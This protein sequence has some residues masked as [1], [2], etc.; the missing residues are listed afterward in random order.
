LGVGI[1]A[2]HALGTLERWHDPDASARSWRRSV[3]DLV[4][5]TWCAPLGRAIGPHR[6][7]V[8]EGC[9]VDVLSTAT[10]AED[11]GLLVIG[12]RGTRSDA[13]D[14]S[15][16]TSL[17]LLHLA[18][19]PVLLVPAGR[20]RSDRSDSLRLRRLLVGVD[21]SQT[22][23]AALVLA[24]EVADRLGGSLNVL[25]V[26]NRVGGFA[27][28]GS[29]RALGRTMTLVEAEL[30]AIRDRGVEAHTVVRSGDAAS[31]LVEIADDVDADLVVVG[32]RGRGGQGELLPGGVSRT[33]ADRVGRPTL[34]VPAAAG[35]VHLPGRGPQPTMA[36][37]TTR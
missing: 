26:F 1:V 13:A 17:Q 29:A 5:R 30:R 6:V 19:L 8:R 34:V 11:A 36:G 22:S 27:R 16:S 20:P 12:H 37:A 7:E 24:S 21:G 4:E 3:A 10:A 18:Q 32:S 33:V 35:R 14:A 28:T 31:T 25:H 15:G 9:P 23:L 2:V